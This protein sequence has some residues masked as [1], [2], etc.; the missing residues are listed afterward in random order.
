M[1]TDFS[2]HFIDGIRLDVSLRNEVRDLGLEDA[3][4]I[5]V[6][7]DN[8]LSGFSSFP[9][10]WWRHYIAKRLYLADPIIS[11]ARK[12]QAPM[13]WDQVID[14]VGDPAVFR[15]GERFGISRD[16]IA[17]PMRDPDGRTVLINAHHRLSRRDWK[18]RRTNVVR[19]LHLVLTGYAFILT[20]LKR[21][22]RSG[23]HRLSVTEEAVLDLHLDGWEMTEIAR[24]LNLRPRTADVHLRSALHKA[25]VGDRES[26]GRTSL[27]AD[28][29]R[30]GEEIPALVRRE[31]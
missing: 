15:E 5:C 1:I 4:V 9:E 10:H 6:E 20:Q 12:S 27:L 22:G 7:K 28:R 17:V 19:S 21:D 24:C 26:C 23:D 31:I 29:I 30:R 16:G 11:F 3:A 25:E 2:S 18:L 8:T 14:A 13:D